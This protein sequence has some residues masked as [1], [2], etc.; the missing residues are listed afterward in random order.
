MEKGIYTQEDKEFMC[1]TNQS[2]NPSRIKELV[3]YIKLNGYKKIGIASCFS[4]KDFAEKLKKCLEQEKIN[5]V[6]VH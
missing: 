4:V 5:A 2:R 1:L 3:N 6:I